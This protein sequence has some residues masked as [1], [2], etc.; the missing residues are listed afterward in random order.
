MAPLALLLDDATPAV[1]AWSCSGYYVNEG[2]LQLHSRDVFVFKDGIVGSNSMLVF[3]Y[4][5]FR[6]K[7]GFMIKT[8]IPFGKETIVIFMQS[9]HI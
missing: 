8:N 4:V 5:A 2:Q 3:Q 1:N 6:L 9:K 7:Y